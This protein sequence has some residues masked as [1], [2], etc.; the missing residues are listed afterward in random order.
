MTAVSKAASRSSFSTASSLDRGSQGVWI[1]D[2]TLTEY[3]PPDG[4]PEQ[5]QISTLIA[6]TH[7]WL[8]FV[9]AGQ[10]VPGIYKRDGTPLVVDDST[11]VLQVWSTLRGSLD[12]MAVQGS[13]RQGEGG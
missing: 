7:G 11:L 2:N 5:I 9:G 4:P 13:S 6:C 12:R 3:D 1:H 8:R 10:P